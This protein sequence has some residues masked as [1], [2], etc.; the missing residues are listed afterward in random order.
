MLYA[1]YQAHSDIM[2]PVRALAGIAAHSI[3]N[4][5]IGMPGHGSVRNLTAAYELIARAGLSHKRPPFNIGYVTAGN[6]DVEVRE[7]VAHVTPFA[8]LLHFKKDIDVV[9]PRVLLVA[10]LSGHFATLL[11]STV[12]TMSRDHDVYLTDWRNARDVNMA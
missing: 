11:R 12:V 8:T 7:E 4:F 2:G 3:G 6:R 10:P 9:Q 5:G 1:A